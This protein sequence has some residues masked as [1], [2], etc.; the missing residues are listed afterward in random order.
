MMAAAAA[1]AA[2]DKQQPQQQPT[3]SFV[4]S[5]FNVA[6]PREPYG[7]QK[8]FINQ[9]VR[10][11]DHQE[12][13]LLEAPTGSGKTL[14]LLCGALAWQHSLKEAKAAAEQAAADK[15]GAKQQQQQQNAGNGGGGGK[16]P[17]AL[18]NSSSTQQQQHQQHADG[19]AA[20]AADQDDEPIVVPK[21]YYA[22]RTHSQIAQVI[23]Q[24]CGCCGEW[25]HR[26][27]CARLA[28]RLPTHTQTT[29]TNTTTHTQQHTPRWCGSSS[30]QPTSPRWRCW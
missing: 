21:I 27:G 9:V 11:I 12:H 5:G 13:A 14:S 29:H 15:A 25:P 1:A 22:T 8:V 3:P 20:G 10:A 7:V 4:C 18:E 24:A 23:L 28:P 6:F 16:Q 17:L 19:D 2:L 30:A 26:A